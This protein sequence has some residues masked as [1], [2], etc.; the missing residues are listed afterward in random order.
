MSSA[1]KDSAKAK[2]N[3]H[4][5]GKVRQTVQNAKRFIRTERGCYTIAQAV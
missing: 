3:L 5:Q 1:L 2:R 4:W